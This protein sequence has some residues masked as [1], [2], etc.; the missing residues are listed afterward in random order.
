MLINYSNHSS[1]QW[2]ISQRTAAEK[3]GE[4]IDIPFPAIPAAASSQDVKDLAAR[5]AEKVSELQPTA[6]MC[7]GEFVF[8]FEFVRILKEKGILCLVACSDRVSEETAGEDGGSRIKT[9]VF[10]FVRFREY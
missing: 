7:Q 5:E 10:R 8:C 2:S 9:S 4:I 6:V 1:Q 3:Y